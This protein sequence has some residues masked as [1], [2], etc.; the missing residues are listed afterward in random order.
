MRSREERK[1]LYAPYLERGYKPPSSAYDVDEEF[2]LDT[3]ATLKKDDLMQYQFLQPIRDYMSD[4]KGAD[5]SN[6]DAEEVVDDFVKHMR[7]FNTNTAITAGEARFISKADDVRKRKAEKAYRIYDQLGNVFMNDGAYGAVDGVKD[8]IFAAAKDPTNYIGI[9]TG[10]LAKL[11]A[12]GVSLTGK[13][14]VRDAVK[15][16][17]ME[18]AL[19]QGGREAAKKAGKRAGI[20][21]AKRAVAAGVT[22]NTKNKIYNETAKRVALEGRRALAKDAIKRERIK[23]G[24]RLDRNALKATIGLDAAFA[25]GQ[26]IQAQQ[27][28]IEAGAQEEFNKLQLGFSPLLG[29]VAGAAQLGFGKFRGVSGFGEEL[30]DPL[31]KVAKNVIEDT[32]LVLKPKDVQEAKNIILKEVDTWNQKVEAGQDVLPAELIHNIMLGPDKKGGVAKLY[33]DLGYKVTREKHISD[34]MTNVM[35]YMED[36]DIAEV[37]EQITK[38]TGIKLGELTGSRNPLGDFVA[39]SINEAGKTLNVMSQVRKTLDSTIISASN[40]LSNTL[41]TIEAKDAVADELRKA[42]KSE[43]FRYGQSVWKRL[44]VSSPA[45]TAVNIAGFTQYYA[46][47]TLADIF[48]STN[49]MVLGLGQLGLGN[50]AGATETFRKARVLTQIQGQKFRNLLDPYTTHDAYMRFLDENKDIKKSLFETMA[51]GV[52]ATAVRY[53]IDPDSKVFRAVDGFTT[54]ASN[55]SGVKA[56]DTFTKSQMFMTELDKYLRLEK[57]VSLKEAMLREENIIDT[58]ALQGALDSTLK[59]VYAKD[60]T[61]KDQPELLR[62]AAKV[63]ETFSNTPGFGTILPFGRFFNNVIA[64]TYQW[65]PLASIDLMSNFVKRIRKD[66]GLDFSEGEV[67]GRMMVGTTAILAAAQY[68][69]G[70]REKG[71]GVYEVETSGGTIIDAKNTFPFSSFLVAGRIANMKMNG[72]EVPREILQEA[73]TQIGVGQLARDVQFGNDINNLLDIF[74]NSDG[75]TRGMTIDGLNKVAGNLVAGFTRPV[76]AINKAA[77]LLTDTDAAKD[78]R[79]ADATGQFTQTATKY[80]DNIYEAFLGRA[81]TITGEELRI[82]TREGDIY[83]PNPFARIFGLTIKPRKTA[84]ERAYSTAMMFPWQANERSAIPAYDKIVNTYLAPILEERTQRLIDSKSFKDASLAVKRKMLRTLL[85][86]TKSDIRYDLG[87]G[88]YGGEGYVAQMRKKA[89]SSVNREIQKEVLNAM[90]ER[91]GIDAKISEMDPR[92][93]DLFL[94]YA[95]YFKDIFDEVKDI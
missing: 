24:E 49:Y 25:F 58:P 15:R 73:G 38:Y 50:K 18:A 1:K 34:V 53:N 92:E 23:V 75:A 4:R 55:L 48:N 65:S 44:L 3:N 7:Y 68:D 76:D 51:G 56:Q 86:D 2:V 21:A 81:D 80:I 88:Y 39:K 22:Q 69:K 40:K 5:Y 27:T 64:T 32:T 29:G 93:L 82:A 54:A 13:K 94:S 85:S 8:Y 79:Q 52:D 67:F 60:Y 66:E 46:G 72:E 17:G 47:Q 35:R 14:F 11:S 42:K 9:A 61:T 45:T 31:E 10:G 90:K 95:E 16:A 89:Y 87:K 71:L 28:L 30:G 91:H 62:T 20:E 70:R 57:G 59:S 84:T 12:A 83:D 77:G 63:T 78:V 37:N 36:A 6:M 26:E 43:K 41:D 19:G 33:R 74:I